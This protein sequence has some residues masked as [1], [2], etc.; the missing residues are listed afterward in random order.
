MGDAKTAPVFVAGLHG[1][2]S[3]EESSRNNFPKAVTE[4]NSVIPAQAGNQF[5]QECW[6]PACAGMTW[7]RV[8]TDPNESVEYRP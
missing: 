8:G 6:L 2:A 3:V 5:A 1:F 7:L 4:S